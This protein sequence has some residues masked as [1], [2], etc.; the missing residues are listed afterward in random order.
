[1]NN[2]YLKSTY[3]I[4]PGE[5]LIDSFTYNDQKQIARYAQY[6]TNAGNNY[7]VR[8]DFNFSGNSAVPDSYFYSDN[9]G[10]SETHQLT[11]DVQGRIT[12]DTC[13]ATNFVTY[14]GYSGNFIV[15]TILFEGTMNDAKIDSLM[16]TDGNITAER[17]WGADNGVW[18]KEGDVIYGHATAANPG[19]KAEIANNVGPL[20]YILSIYNFGGWSDYISKSIMNKVTGVADGLPPGGFNYTIQ[21]D[22]TGRVSGLVPAG[23]GAGSGEINYN[24]Y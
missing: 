11:F 9:A 14:Y 3:T 17:L 8:Y 13:A 24:Y 2:S 10:N 5:Q 12:K 21:V 16:V 22:G 20:L 7:F 19:Y 4:S 1:V 6:V 23:V 18:S 15:C